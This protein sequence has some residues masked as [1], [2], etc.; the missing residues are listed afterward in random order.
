[1]AR[2]EEVAAKMF[3][4]VGSLF[5]AVLVLGIGGVILDNQYPELLNPAPVPPPT[6]KRTVFMPP[7]GNIKL[8]LDRDEVRNPGERVKNAMKECIGSPPALIA[9]G[10]NAE[11]EEFLADATKTD[12]F[13]FYCSSPGSWKILAGRTGLVKMRDGKPVDELIFFMN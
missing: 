9:M 8:V 1:M 11:I 10:G 6:I 13:Y 7:L 3:W 2:F 12:V 4:A 5:V